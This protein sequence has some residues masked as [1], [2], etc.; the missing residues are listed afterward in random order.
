[1][2]DKMQEVLQSQSMC[3][4]AT[5]ADGKP[6]CSLMAYVFA[7]EERS[8]IMVTHRN[9][10]KFQN[11]IANPQVSLLIDTRLQDGDEK[12]SYLKALT[13][14]GWCETIESQSESDRLKQ[15]LLKSNRHLSEFVSHPEAA[16]IGVKVSSLQL[17]EGVNDSYFE[18]FEN[19]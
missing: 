6:H 4:L 5:V 8:I 19:T 3:V 15:L 14:K 17:L 12:R 1:M 16:V 10:K 11:V 18:T 13:V 9:T 2:Q 7:P